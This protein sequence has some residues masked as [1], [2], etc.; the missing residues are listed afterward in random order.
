[1]R[2]EPA[3]RGAPDGKVNILLVDDRPDK[4]LS[5]EVMLT[6]LGEN[7]V[8]ATSGKEALRKLLH[9][10]FAVIL[11]D[12]N[13]PI[14]DGFETAAMIRQ[15]Q[16]SETTP[17]IFFSAVND[18]E[19]HVSRGYSLGAVDYILSPVVPEILRAKIAVFVDLFRKTEEVKRRAEER[20]EFIREQAARAEAE[21]AQQR[22]A[23]LAEASN[24]LAGSLD[25]QATFESLARLAVPK[26]G[27]FC[28]IDVAEESGALRQV[29]VAHRDPEEEGKL[30]QLSE[31]YPE[32]WD[33][34][35]AA[36]HVIQTGK[37]QVSGELTTDALREIFPDDATRELVQSLSPVSYI[38]V[39]LRAR[40]RVLGA[41]TLV[42]TESRAGGA[43]A[44]A[45]AEELSQRAA[46]ALDNAALYQAAQAAR[47]EAERANLAKD[48][49]L[50]MLSH[51]LRTP[52]TPVLI[53]VA[54]L[55]SE[56]NLPEQIRAGLEMIRRNVELEARL[57][58]DLLDLTRISKGKV[59]LQ[60]EH[61]D[62]HQLLR[63]ALEICEPDIIAKGLHVKTD[64]RATRFA[65]HGDPARLQQVFWN[66]IKNAVKFTPQHGDLAL[67]T[68]SEDGEL[69]VE[70]LDSGIGIGRELLSKIFDAF[71]QGERARAGGLGLGLAITKAL[72]EL[73]KGRIE[74]ESEGPGR[75]A[76][77]TVWFP[78]LETAPGLGVE[79]APV[80]PSERRSM[81]VLLVEDHEDSNRS[82]TQLLR[83]RGYVVQSAEDVR[84]AL[85][86]AAQFDFD[87]L[88]SDMGLPDGTGIDLMNK[89]SASRPVFGIALT[90][91]GMES[92]VHRSS[93]AGFQHHLIKPVDLNRLDALIQ[94]AP[95][96]IAATAPALNAGG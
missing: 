60:L 43:S 76:R 25:Y 61:V 36:T 69:R 38:A 88:I 66:L 78:A 72:V 29:A 51:E 6:D 63:N 45:L 83:R 35:H 19:T 18:T 26:L 16:R 46:L 5:L 89:L 80:P 8:T 94:S 32:N 41:I 75:G 12:V 22:L 74:A 13:M 68:D 11:L 65:L 4:L 28:I 58:D 73:H 56:E 77:F 95:P 40:G 49:F 50:A 53:S 48:N 92:D 10:D 14:M 93:A 31:H 82:L 86:T 23:F 90:G 47:T 81:R 52:L 79:N 24:V 87:V 30:R 2:F 55:E 54:M 59:Q 34:K 67:N 42:N 27:D 15:R 71:E 85:Q 20:A 37:P 17:I 3:A 84:S 64:F 7:L 57:I 21:A 39:P 96:G 70:V 9:E 91:F 33:L 62:A 44:L 1:M